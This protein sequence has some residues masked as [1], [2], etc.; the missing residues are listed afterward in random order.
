MNPITIFSS[1][2]LH[3]LSLGIHHKAF[4]NSM[5]QNAVESPSPMG[6][7]KLPEEEEYS[8]HHS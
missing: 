6:N 5:A 7:L 3:Q 8:A 1:N 4:Q 2:A